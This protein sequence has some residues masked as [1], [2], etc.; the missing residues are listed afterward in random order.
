MQ[1]PPVVHGLAREA[2]NHYLLD[3][4]GEE[5]LAAVMQQLQAAQL[6]SAQGPQS[7]DSDLDD[8]TSVR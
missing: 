1:P 5:R 4:L 6:P 7:M 8:A 2:V 3:V